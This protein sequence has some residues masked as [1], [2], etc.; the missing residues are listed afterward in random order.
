MA[1][2]DTDPV[3]KA[4]AHGR[5]ARLTPNLSR[6]RPHIA[7]CG[8]GPVAAGSSAWPGHRRPPVHWIIKSTWRWWPG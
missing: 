4:V 7:G 6:E 1:D 2:R 5:Q 8:A 3:A